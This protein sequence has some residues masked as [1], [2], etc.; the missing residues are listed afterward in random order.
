M[1][2]YVLDFEKKAA[3]LKEKLLSGK[4][5][6]EYEAKIAPSLCT[7]EMF[8]VFFSLCNTF[9]RAKVVRF[10]APAL[11]E[12]WYGAYKAAVRYISSKNYNA[13]WVKAD[14]MCRSERISTQKLID[15]ISKGYHE[16][17]RRG[18]SFDNELKTAML[19]AEINCNR[20]LSYNEKTVKPEQVNRY[21]YSA[22]GVKL[23]EL[24]EE[25]IVFD[26]RCAFCDEN[27]DVHELYWY[28]N[29]CGRRVVKKFSKNHALDVI[30]TSSQYLSSQLDFNG[31][32]QYGI[33]PIYH[34][35]IPGYN[36]LRHASSIWSLVC[37]YRIT[38]DKFIL[39][40]VEGALGF[41]V[42]NSFY[43]YKKPRTEENT[44]YIADLE[45]ME[46]KLGGNGLAIIL[47]TEYMNVTGS[48]KY[49]KLCKELGNGIL[50]LLDK[51]TGEFTHVLSIPSLEV[52]TKM[53][54]VYYD[55][56]AVFAL[57]RLYGLTGEQRWLD[58]ASTAVDRFIRED[59]TKYRDHWVAYSM[60][61]ITKHKP[62]EEYFAFALRNAQVNLKK[63]HDQKTTYHTYLELLCV[64]F[65]LY[66][67]VISENIKVDYL[68]EFDAEYFV[69]TIFH[70]AHYMLNG[71][72]YPEYA[73]YL[74]FPEKI[75]GSFFVRHDGYRIRIDD[76]Q[77]FC[78]AYYSL[79]R[80]Y[81]KLDAIRNEAEKNKK[82]GK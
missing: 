62:C 76:I 1:N 60:N 22:C 28:G 21:L 48:D 27:N 52:K 30:T 25:V 37:A 35:E 16:F 19:E 36:I 68:S 81:E 20:V 59:Y 82:K 78:G 51:E 75:L 8:T 69:E 53:R 57:A 5:F 49:V 40:Q 46:V 29:N 79:Y 72:A 7:K 44:A 42:R 34:R 64:T 73:M 33:F 3:L 15:T 24:P 41:L 39:K 71:Y 65:E 2:I 14:I 23:S 17:Y 50:E 56:E 47:L 18:I 38:G 11:S 32:F 31:K 80:N 12:A 10:T 43:K 6:E 77:H 66:D 54:T 61:E 45:K 67:R 58:A 9:S 26:C 13:V 63:I 70:R 4:S 55:G 74:K